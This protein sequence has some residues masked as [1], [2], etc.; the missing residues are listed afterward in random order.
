MTRLVFFSSLIGLAAALVVGC[1]DDKPINKLAVTKSFTVPAVKEMAGRAS[2][3]QRVDFNNDGYEDAV[4]KYFRDTTK[5][6]SKATSKIVRGFEILAL[7][8]F[9]ATTQGFTKVFEHKYFY[10][11][12]VEGRDVNRDGVMELVVATDGGGNSALASRGMAVI[13]RTA[14]TYK[15]LA[16][17]DEGAPELTTSN[18]GLTMMISHAV[19]APEF[20]SAAD[21]VQV[22][23]SV[24]VFSD[25]AAVRRKVRDTTLRGYLV[26]SAE[27][28][29]QAKATLS[30]KPKDGKALGE[31]YAAAV[32]QLLY[33]QKLALNNEAQKLRQNEQAYWAQ[34]LPYQHRQSLN[35][36]VSGVYAN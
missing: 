31:M 20:G 27:R 25:D 22:I 23:D 3:V 9:N 34:T 10:G 6:A 21:I 17:L 5:A 13:G 35:D 30:T 36:I 32:S 1:K 19:F 14:S 8:E 16:A 15:E 24:H 2:E 29:R 33:M 12:S 28:Y 7:Y 26:Q 4:V 18:D 11:T